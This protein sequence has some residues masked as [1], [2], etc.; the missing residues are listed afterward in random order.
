[1]CRPSVD[2]LFQS[3]AQ[4]AIR[5]VLSVIMTGM[6]SDGCDGVRAIKA[7]GGYCISQDE[8]SSGVF[9]MPKAVE[10]ADLSDEQV[11]LDR[12]ASRIAAIVSASRTLP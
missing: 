9:G 3:I 12:L 7:R 2:V 10:D 4:H 11:P 1:G 5:G 6:G 8:A